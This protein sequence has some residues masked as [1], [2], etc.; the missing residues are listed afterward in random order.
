MGFAMVLVL[1]SIR[2]DVLGGFGGKALGAFPL[3]LAQPVVIRQ[4]GFGQDGFA[5]L[6][7]L[8]CHQRNGC[9]PP[10]PQGRRHT[11]HTR[12]IAVFIIAQ[13]CANTNK[14]QGLFAIFYKLGKVSHG[15][16]VVVQQPCV[17]G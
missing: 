7:H 16:G 1:S 17:G 10:A 3:G 9:G 14:K 12:N 2:F 4:K 5:P 15:A 8:L 6:G 13:R 11:E